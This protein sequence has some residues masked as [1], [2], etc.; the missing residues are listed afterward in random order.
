MKKPVI[1]LLLGI[2]YMAQPFSS[3]SINLIGRVVTVDS[4]GVAGATVKLTAAGIETTTDSSGAFRLVADPTGHPITAAGFKPVPTSFNGRVV[5][6]GIAEEATMEVYNAL[7]KRIAVPVKKQ[8][9]IGNYAFNPFASTAVPLSSGLYVL[10]VR[11]GNEVRHFKMTGMSSSRPMEIRQNKAPGGPVLMKV[12]AEEV[13]D[14]L[15]VAKEGFFE[16]RVI[17]DNYEQDVGK[18]VLVD[19]PLI[20]KTE[21]IGNEEIII[22]IFCFN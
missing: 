13:K 1:L 18:V 12:K 5:S 3:P 8:F 10:R 7:G 15:V 22:P 6:F 2:G 4:V 16:Q 19:V 20:P 21:N 17:V 11:I 9:T 14:T